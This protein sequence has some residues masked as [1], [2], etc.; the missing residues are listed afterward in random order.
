MFLRR[1]AAQRLHKEEP[2]RLHSDKQSLETSGEKLRQIMRAGEIPPEIKDA[3][4]SA[5]REMSG[6]HRKIFGAGLV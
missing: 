2:D 5:Y 4:K 6:K 3:I 1:Q